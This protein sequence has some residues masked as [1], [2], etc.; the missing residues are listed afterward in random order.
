MRVAIV[1]DMSLAVESIRRV[2]L[3][4]GKH[5]VAWTARDGVEAVEK[6]AT[7]TPD[8]ILM[9]LIMPV[10]DGVEATRAIMRTA[11]CAILVVTATVEGN[12]TRVYEA[13]GAGALDAVETPN[14]S[15][16]GKLL[17]IKLDM[18]NRHVLL[19]D[20]A[21]TVD[22]HMAK[23]MVSIESGKPAHFLI[24]VGASAGGPA[25]LVDLLAQLPA[26][27]PAAVVL[28]QHIDAI[29]AKGLGEW[30]A[31]KSKL[32]VKIASSGEQL[33]EGQIYL[34]GAAKHLLIDA[35]GHL[36]ERH[37]P[38]AG[39]YTP[40]INLFFESFA[41]NWRRSGVCVLLTGMGRDGATG[42]KSVRE[43]GF[44][45]VAQ[46]RESC[47]VYGMPKAAAE[48]GAASHIMP[49]EHIGPWLVSAAERH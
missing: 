25:A 34:S 37:D 9:D 21:P 31:A 43:A 42:L 49:L 46:S 4:S 39:S 24:G 17:L 29:F 8:L 33:M 10:M 2:L 19:Q 27:L 38:S 16:G 5:S 20:E 30:L 41:L 48:L 13:L 47:A 22:A 40:S 1:N 18:M 44:T 35:S 12:V 7:D 23:E 26:N 3:A 11:P 14:F 32:P 45:T 6:N 15:D 36:V 28:L